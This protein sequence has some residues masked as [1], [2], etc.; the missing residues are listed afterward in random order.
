MISVEQDQNHRTVDGWL[1]TGQICIQILT[2]QDP[3]L[4]MIYVRQSWVLQQLFDD[5]GSQ[6]SIEVQIGADRFDGE[7]LTS[8]YFRGP[9]QESSRATIVGP[10]VGPHAASIEMSSRYFNFNFNL[11][12]NSLKLKL[13]WLIRTASPAGDSAFETPFYKLYS[14]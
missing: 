1:I 5:S 7:R 12:F 9:W 10:R 6:S 8:E 3:L 14:M 11:K 13:K 2:A 4:A